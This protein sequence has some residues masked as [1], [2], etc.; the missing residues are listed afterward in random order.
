MTG[1]PG[2]GP[3]KNHSY[4]VTAFC[5]TI[6]LASTSYSTIRSTSRNG[7]RCGMRASI[8]RVVWTTGDPGGAEPD[9]P[10]AASAG[11]S[12]G[13]GVGGAV[14]S[15]IGLSGSVVVASAAPVGAAGQAWTA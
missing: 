12:I 11:G 3:A 5:P 15:V 6:R 9:A 2:K 1:S 14:A 7:H 13:H 10:G 8:S 4:A